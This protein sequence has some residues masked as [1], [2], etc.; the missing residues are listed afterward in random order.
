MLDHESSNKESLEYAS[1]YTDI[2]VLLDLSFN[3]NSC[4]LASL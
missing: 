1:Y 2:L 4:S 3:W